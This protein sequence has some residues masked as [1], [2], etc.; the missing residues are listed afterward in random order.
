MSLFLKLE[1]SAAV[2][3]KHWLVPDEHL[4]KIAFEEML[5]DISTGKAALWQVGQ[6]LQGVAVTYEVEGLLFVHYLRGHQL[7]DKFTREILLELAHQQ[8]LAGLACQ[9]YKASLA[10]LFARVGWQVAERQENP[11]IYIM[12]LQDG[13]R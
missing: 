10:R 11:T 6:P 7:F 1:P 4:K 2:G 13:R 3:L 12:R 9:T 8:G 5:A